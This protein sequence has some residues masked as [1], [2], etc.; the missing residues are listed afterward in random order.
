MAKVLSVDKARPSLGKLVDEV[1]SKGEPVVITKR[2]GTAA[3]LVSYEDYAALKAV[4]EG[5]VKTRLR[6]ALRELRRTV[7]KARLPVG[8]VDEAIRE[9]RGLR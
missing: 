1:V 7:K 9:T 2:A 5:K 4:A 8:L 3:V 6:Q